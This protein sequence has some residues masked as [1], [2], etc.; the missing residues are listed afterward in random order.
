MVSNFLKATLL[1]N[2]ICDAL[3]YPPFCGYP[4]SEK[5]RSPID[6]AGSFLSCSRSQKIESTLSAL[7]VLSFPTLSELQIK[8]I[9]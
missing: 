5:D 3:G 6:S 4:E 9:H 8:G 2:R 7:P 1:N